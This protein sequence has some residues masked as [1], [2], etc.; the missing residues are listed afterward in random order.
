MTYTVA[1]RSDPEIEA[2][3]DDRRRATVALLDLCQMHLTEFAD[4]SE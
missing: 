3:P 2:L 4:S 1:A